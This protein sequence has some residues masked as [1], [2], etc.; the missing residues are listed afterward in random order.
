MTKTLRKEVL[1]SPRTVYNVEVAGGCRRASVYGSK[2]TR[3]TPGNPG[4]FAFSLTPVAPR[5]PC[6]RVSAGVR[7]SSC[8]YFDC[9]LF[10]VSEVALSEGDQRHDR[11]RPEGHEADA[12]FALRL[13][14]QQPSDEGTRRG[15]RTVL[16]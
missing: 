8:S 15:P 12:L 6:Q 2:Q 1:A 3:K 14:G 11:D 9:P 7:H 4:V 10:P 5:K 16:R 13:S